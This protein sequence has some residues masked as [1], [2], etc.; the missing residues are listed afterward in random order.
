[1]KTILI[2]DKDLGFVFWLG[3]IL[4]AA[5]YT[6]LPAKG[7]ADATEI[8]ST[9]RLSIDILVAPQSE[10]NLHGLVERLRVTSPNLQVVAVAGERDQ[11]IAGD[12]FDA[13]WKRGPCRRDAAAKSEWLD[14]IYSLSHDGALTSARSH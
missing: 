9:L 4:D 1:V 14:L 6:A 2:V 3:Q 5:G 12:R 10:P 11:A 8:V 7:V 13:V